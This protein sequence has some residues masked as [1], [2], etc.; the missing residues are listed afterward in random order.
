MSQY[1]DSFRV[2]CVGTLPCNNNRQFCDH[3]KGPV[4]IQNGKV[5]S[6]E[7][8]SEK[9]TRPIKNV[10][11]TSHCQAYGV[12]EKVIQDNEIGEKP[13]W[14]HTWSNVRGYGNIVVA[15]NDSCNNIHGKV[16]PYNRISSLSM[17]YDGPAVVKDAWKMNKAEHL[18]E[19]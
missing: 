8:S 18:K 4:V 7:S 16:H 10:S 17:P 1:P 12:P 3:S 2:N 9:L 19:N 15:T 14:T 5:V 11:T 6:E 13:K